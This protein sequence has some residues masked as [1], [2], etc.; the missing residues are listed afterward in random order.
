MKTKRG[1]CVMSQELLNNK[2]PQDLIASFCVNDA[3]NQ[4]L[5]K[6]GSI[7]YAI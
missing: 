1:M 6:Y 2:E 3:L 5:G 4:P 7:A